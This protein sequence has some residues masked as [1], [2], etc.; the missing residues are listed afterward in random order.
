MLARNAPTLPAE[1]ALPGGC[2][3]EAKL[4]GFRLLL[5]SQGRRAPAL[6]QTRAGR[7][8]GHQFPEIA[9]A[10]RALPV[11]TVLDGELVIWHAGRL[12]FNALLRRGQ[13]RRRVA[14]LSVAMP[15][16]FIAFDA[17]AV[18]DRDG[19]IRP[20]PYVERRARLLRTLDGIQ[21]PIQAIDATTDR[22]AAAAM[23]P[24][25][26]PLGVEGIVAKGQVSRYE[27]SHRG[28]LKHRAAVPV[29]AAVVGTFGPARRPRAL[30]LAIEGEARPVIS[31][32]LDAALR[33]QVGRVVT[34][35][36]PTNPARAS[37]YRPVAPGL[38]V[39]VMR[40][41]TDRDARVVVMRM[42]ADL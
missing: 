8:I 24:A 42:K 23:I 37:M 3:Y 34:D 17:L 15:A 31:A 22:D 20:L 7:L 27:G 25:L 40:G 6:L 12:D 19:D 32:P 41:L 26:L 35:L 2:S 18:R 9:D 36:P 11:G 10:G 28:W 21:P 38:A 39:E 5:F 14:A 30:L 1:D 29:D 16:S 33:A 13:E 4:D